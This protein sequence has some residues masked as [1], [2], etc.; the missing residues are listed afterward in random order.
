MVACHLHRAPL[1]ASIGVRLPGS[2]AVMGKHEGDAIPL[3]HGRSGQKA[4][5][6]VSVHDGRPKAIRRR[7]G[8]RFETPI[9][10]TGY[11]FRLEAEQ[12]EARFDRHFRAACECDR[13]LVTVAGQLPGQQSRVCLRAAH[14]QVVDKKEDSPP[15][16]WRRLLSR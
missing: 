2:V 13:H 7:Q 6:Q 3:G 12:L 9:A 10:A 11:S 8:R 5:E 16:W 15:D 14:T 4:G 1:Q